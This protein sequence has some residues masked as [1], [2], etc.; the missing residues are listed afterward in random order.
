MQVL[1]PQQHHQPASTFIHLSQSSSVCLASPSSS[2]LG[3]LRSSA[4][5]NGRLPFTAEQAA[6]HQH[7]LASR[8]VLRTPRLNLIP[9]HS[10]ATSTKEYLSHLPT[11]Q[12][13]E[14]MWSIQL[15]SA[16]SPISPPSSPDKH[17]SHTSNRAISTHD[18]I[19]MVALQFHSP[20][21]HL[22]QPTLQLYVAPSYRSQGYAT[23]AA[24]R[25]LSWLFYCTDEAECCSDEPF[26]R[27]AKVDAVTLPT[28]SP[29]AE[30]ICEKLGLKR[31][32]ERES[33]SDTDSETESKEVWWGITKEEFGDLWESIDE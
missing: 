31:V 15:D 2:R 19:G 11:V 8:P 9:T 21:P 30:R 24:K 26:A 25:V 14:C 32:G 28:R 29:A 20:S 7:Q 6:A 10:T 16:T 17:S 13:W 5:W 12:P 4:G 1:S 33:D 23:E 3:D 27:D 22:Y 18:C